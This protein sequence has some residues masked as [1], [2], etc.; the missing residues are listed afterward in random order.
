[1][2]HRPIP[3]QIALAGLERAR[4]DADD[5]W[6]GET[7][8]EKIGVRLLNARIADYRSEISG[9]PR[10][11][12]YRLR[13]L[14]QKLKLLHQQDNFKGKTRPQL[15]LQKKLAL[16]GP[17]DTEDGRKLRIVG[18]E[19]RTPK[20]TVELYVDV[21]E[22]SGERPTL[23]ATGAMH[24]RAA[25]AFV[26]HAA[27]LATL[28]A[29]DPFPSGLW[30]FSLAPT[31]EAFRHPSADP[32]SITITL[33]ALDALAAA[34]TATLWAADC[35]R[36]TEALRGRRVTKGRAKGAV[37]MWRYV[38]ASKR[39]VLS[40]HPRHTSIAVRWWASSARTIDY[41]C[42]GVVYL[43]KVGD[44]GAW[45]DDDTAGDPLSTS[46]VLRTLL[47]LDATDDLRTI[48]EAERLR[49]SYAEDA[50]GWLLRNL[51]DEH[52]WWLMRT[53]DGPPEDHPLTQYFSAEIAA[54]IPEFAERGDR[55]A[56]AYGSLLGR[57]A[58]EWHGAGIPVD[59]QARVPDLGTTTAFVQ[60]AWATRVVYRDFARAAITRYLDSLD[61]LL[62]TGSADAAAWASTLHFLG[63]L[64]GAQLPSDE[65]Q[66][67]RDAVTKLRHSADRGVIPRVPTATLPR[68]ARRHARAILATRAASTAQGHQLRKD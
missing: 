60:A 15:E 63:Q 55:Y 9:K 58:E 40:P 19:H 32:G 56:A 46:Y 4:N 12:R 42:A 2:A 38:E 10:H 59:Q 21:E 66:A 51:E 64:S 67:I 41:L 62:Q 47:D 25:Q 16:L 48:A 8:G 5:A 24:A 68:W 37:G 26:R 52:G 45:G 7:L 18:P 29:L 14:L 11:T 35:R 61:S 57:L 65:A 36:F 6:T 3:P 53:H 43:A 33:R 54:T 50:F 49:T 30:G 1:V 44:D 34:S 22:A 39:L 27:G 17:Y 23:R 28:I 31:T 20:G 13:P